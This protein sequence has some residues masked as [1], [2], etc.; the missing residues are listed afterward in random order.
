MS[1]MCI[2]HTAN[3]NVTIEE[4][5]ITFEL[6]DDCTGKGLP[7]KIK[8][9]ERLEMFYCHGQGYDSRHQGVQATVLH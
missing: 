3:W 4:Y 9:A 6:C 8:A 5:F 7:E 1:V 2:V